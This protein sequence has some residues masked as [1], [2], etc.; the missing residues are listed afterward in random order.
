MSPGVTNPK[1]TALTCIGRTR[2]NWMYSMLAM[3]SGATR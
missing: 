2:P 1:S 3:K